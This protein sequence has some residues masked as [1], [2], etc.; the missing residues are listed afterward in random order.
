MRFD[1]SRGRRVDAMRKVWREPG[2]REWHASRQRK[3]SSRTPT[4]RA[5]RRRRVDSKLQ[6]VDI[7]YRRFIENQPWRAIARHYGCHHRLV[8]LICQGKVH[9]E[10]V[11]EA[12]QELG[13]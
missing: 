7:L 11:A 6:V 1:E 10:W 4:D 3:K 13:L 9:V 2:Y 8:T 12:K 5:S